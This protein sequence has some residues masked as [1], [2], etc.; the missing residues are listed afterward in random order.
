MPMASNL[1]N[2][3]RFRRTRTACGWTLIPTPRETSCPAASNKDM[4][5]KPWA[6]KCRAVTRPPTPAPMMAICGSFPIFLD[7]GLLLAVRTLSYR[8]VLVRTSSLEILGAS[9][10]S[11]TKKCFIDAN[12]ASAIGYGISASPGLHCEQPL[13]VNRTASRLQRIQTLV[14]CHLTRKASEVKEE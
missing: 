11:R 10:Y 13:D 9:S 8:L 6:C 1:G 5:L 3:P 14:R 7:A 4:F 2:N 12:K